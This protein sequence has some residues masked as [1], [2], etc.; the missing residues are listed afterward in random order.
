MSAPDAVWRTQV[1]RIGRLELVPVRADRDAE[2]LHS[3]LTTERAAFFGMTSATVHDVFRDYRE[4]EAS[5]R[6]RAYLGLHDGRAAFLTELYDPAS[7][8]VG[9][10]YPAEPGDVGMH[11]L[12]AAPRTPVSG[13]TTAAMGACL[14][15]VFSDP[16]HHRVVVEPDV[17]NEKV[18]AVNAR[19]GFRVFADVDL[20]DKR[21]RLSVCTRNDFGRALSLPAAKHREVR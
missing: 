8:P 19:L 3:W 5:T 18:H 1:A 10:A 14:H 15:Y 21:A 9:S 4:Y 17:R 11:F 16:V 7:D 2:L 12:S 20:P 6:H 13:F